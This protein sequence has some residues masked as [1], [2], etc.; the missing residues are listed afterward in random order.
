MSVRCVP[1]AIAGALLFGALVTPAAALELFGPSCLEKLSER[2][3]V[4]A[5]C[6]HQ[7][8]RTDARCRE[9][10]ARMHAYMDECARKGKSKAEI[11]AAMSRG[12]GLAGEKRPA[13]R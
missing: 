3:R 4:W 12:Y 6:T 1:R 2:T 9:A 10:T 11:D 7:F 8:D 5:E 13:E